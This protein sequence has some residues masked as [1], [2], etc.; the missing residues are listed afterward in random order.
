MRNDK[1]SAECVAVIGSMTQA[2]QAKGFLSAASV[3]A[4][5][6]KAD[7]SQTGRGCAYGV[8]YPAAQDDTVRAVLMNVS[9]RPM[10][11]YCGGGR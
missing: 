4:E 1:K 2:M 5:V 8:A 6:I 10:S 9:I 11:I 7:S 3:R